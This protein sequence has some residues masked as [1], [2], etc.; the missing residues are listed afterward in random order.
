MSIEKIVVIG[1]GHA[2]VQMVTSLRQEGFAG[3]LILVSDEADIPYHKPPLSKAFLKH[4][5]AELQLLKAE[6]FYKE[7]NVTLMF[8][9]HV[10][11][12]D[13][14]AKRVDF[15]TGAPLTYDR[16]VLATG[17][18]PRLATLPGGDLQG[19]L[20]L[21]TQADAF[22]LRNRISHVTDVV[23]L[24]GG[25]I[26]MEAAFTLAGLGKKVTI[27]EFAPRILNRAV[28]QIVSDHMTARAKLNGIDVR[29]NTALAAIKGVHGTVTHVVTADG[30][31]IEAQMVVLGIGVVPNVEI[32]QAAGL[33]CANGICVDLH[34]RTNDPDVFAVGDVVSYDHW[35]AERVVRLES[36][37]NAT[38]Q[39]KLAAKTILG[40][41]E[42]YHTVPW[43]WSDQG[44]VKLQMAGLSFDPDTFITRGD[45]AANAFSVYHFRKG[46]LVSVDSVNKGAD[47]MVARKMLAAGFSP[48]PEQLADLN[49]DLRTLV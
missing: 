3:E 33:K 39:A 24:G 38:D 21:R 35:L 43:F 26:G 27:V 23:V 2:G 15:T 11:A 20:A 13:L 14:A 41:A 30:A 47:H 31:E 44:D 7:N 12:L 16:L 22:K 49:M 5:D 19:V 29:V 17:A 45:P 34:M 8:G 1:A 4:P 28:S 48:T 6:E 25:F 36:V 37:Q 18:R 46:K 42:D 40:K 32:A 9:R 10:S